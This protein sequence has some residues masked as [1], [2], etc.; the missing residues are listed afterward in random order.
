MLNGLSGEAVFAEEVHERAGQDEVEEGV[1]RSGQC[2]VGAACPRRAPIDGDDLHGLK[3]GA[4]V[5]GQDGGWRIGNGRDSV[6][7]KV[8]EWNDLFWTGNGCRRLSDVLR[9]SLSLSHET[10]LL[11]MGGEPERSGWGESW[12]DRPE[13]R[14]NYTPDTS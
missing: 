8:S 9:G 14:W 3:H 4:A 7:D 11:G 13:G 6:S 12:G 5:I 10:S 1:D 2:G